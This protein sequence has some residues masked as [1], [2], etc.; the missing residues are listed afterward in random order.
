MPNPRIARGPAAVGKAC[1]SHARNCHSAGLPCTPYCFCVDE[2][3][4]FILVTKHDENELYMIMRKKVIVRRKGG[5]ERMGT[6]LCYENLSF[7]INYTHYVNVQMKLV[8]ANKFSV[9]IRNYI[10]EYF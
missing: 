3:M 8:I 4:Y 6:N 5:L 9:F 7:E 1:S 10:G 2:A